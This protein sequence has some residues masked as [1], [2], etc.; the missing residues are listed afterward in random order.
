MSTGGL[1]LLTSNPVFI[2]NI[3]EVVTDEVWVLC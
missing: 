3:L 1:G 2:V